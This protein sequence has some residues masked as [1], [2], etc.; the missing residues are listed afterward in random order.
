MKRFHLVTLLIGAALLAGLIWSIGLDSLVRDFAVLGWGLVPLVLIE[1]VAAIFHTMGWRRCLSGPH[2]KLSFW[3]VFGIRMAG[4]SINYLTPTASLGGEVTK[5]ALLFDHFRS[6]D[7]ATGVIVDKLS[8]SLAQVALASTGSIVIV[9]FLG[10]SLPT[11]VW[12]GVLAGSVLLAAGI[13]GFLLVQKYGKLGAVVRW[14]VA[15]KVGGRTMAKAGDH[16]TQVDLALKV[17]Y[18]NQPWDLPLSILWHV[19]GLACGVLQSWY[20]LYLMTGHSHLLLAAGIWCLG[21]LVDLVAFA[22]PLDIGVLEATRVMVFRIFGLTSAL[23]LT[24]GVALRV[25]Q[26]FWALIGLVIYLG[27]VGG[28]KNKVVPQTETAREGR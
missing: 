10:V 21:T 19:G 8:Y 15:R 9:L 22:I 11:G 18:R 25:E 13:G 14:L 28:R 4:S 17:F 23:G 26:I 2:R 24:F 1:G 27:F 16:I 12:V 7:A 20:F 3:R 6:A 5:S